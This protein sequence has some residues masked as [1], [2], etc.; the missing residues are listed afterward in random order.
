M[1]IYFLPYTPIISSVHFQKKYN[2]SISFFS[3]NMT[4]LSQ[5]KITY[6]LFEKQ[7]HTHTR[8]RKM[9]SDDAEMLTSEVHDL[10]TRIT[11]A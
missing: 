7:T 10:Y 2:W 3:P 11:V 6:I 8:E 1:F 9:G 5:N 4:N